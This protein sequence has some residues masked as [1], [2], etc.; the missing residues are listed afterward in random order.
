MKRIVVSAGLAAI[1]AMSLHASDYAPDFTAMNAT[2]PWSVSGTLRGFYDDN[3]TTTSKKN[4]SGGFE[5][6]PQIG[7]IMPLQQTE[8]GLRYTYGLYYYQAR[9]NQ[10][11]NPIDQTHQVDLW[12]D[13]AFTQ[14]LEGKVQDTFVSQQDPELSSSPT[15]LPY[16]AEGNNIENVG[17]V[18]G[19]YEWSMPFSTDVGYQNTWWDYQEHG[20]TVA[21]LESG[22]GATYAGLLNQ[23][24]HSIWVNLNYQYLPDLAFLVGYNFEYDDYTGDEP[25]GIAL[26]G[27]LYSDSRNAISH[28]VYVGVQYAMTANLSILANAGFEYSDDYNLPDF[29]HQNPNSYQPTANIAVTY[30]YLPGDYVQVGFTQ[31][32]ASAPLAAVDP[33][34]GSVTLYQES[35]VIYATVNYEITP[36]LVGSV[37]GHYEHSTFQ[38]GG[39]N[40]ESQDWYSFGLNLA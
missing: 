10:G 39:A 20:A 36:K 27:P 11:A 24:D 40:G 12:I 34:S 22:Q 14:R 28:K 37:V 6:S 35:S 32:E 15:A 7:L 33:S 25:I 17:T 31:S 5:F 2:K 13:H 18:T 19:H 29:D 4:G 23:D 9:E 1:G 21:G 8:L 38:S 26:A 16:R 30:T 3:Y